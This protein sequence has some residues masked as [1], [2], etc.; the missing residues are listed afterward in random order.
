MFSMASSLVRL[1]VLLVTEIT[2]CE[3][4]AAAFPADPPEKNRKAAAT[5]A[6]VAAASTGTPT[7]R[8]GFLV[9]LGLE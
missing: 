9:V 4:R 1:D 6:S 7:R 3:A 8:A 2:L 5:P